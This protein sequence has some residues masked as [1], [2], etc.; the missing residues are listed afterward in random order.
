VYAFKV[1]DDKSMVYSVIVDPSNG[2]VLYKSPGHSFQMGGF[3]M[4]QAGGMR[5]GHHMGG[6]AWYSQKAPS[7]GTTTPGGTAGTSPSDYTT[8]SGLQ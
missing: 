6:Q 4:G 2:Q 3:G 7:G 5:H 1:I 8:P